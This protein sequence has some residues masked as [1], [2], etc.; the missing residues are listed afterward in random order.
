LTNKVNEER[1]IHYKIRES[2]LQRDNYKCQLCGNKDYL[3]VH[4]KHAIYKGGKSV[5]KNL[6]TL[7]EDCHTFAPEDGEQ[8]N[9]DYLLNKNKF[10]YE[11]F[12]K[13]SNPSETFAYIFMEFMKDKVHEYVLAGIIDEKQR[14]EII[15]FEEKRFLG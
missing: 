6:I 7:C 12:K 8:A 4:H 13:V 9:M 5:P 15:K 3:E 11:E 14:D 2:I 10:V 1:R